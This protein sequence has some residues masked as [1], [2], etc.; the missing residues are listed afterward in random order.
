MI[1]VADGPGEQGDA[2][3]PGIRDRGPDLVHRQLGFTHGD[4]ADNVHLARVPGQVRA[5]IGCH[6]R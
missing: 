2:A 3:G 4:Q 6:R 5:V 1:A